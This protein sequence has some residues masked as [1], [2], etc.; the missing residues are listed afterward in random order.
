MSSFPSPVEPNAKPSS[1]SHSTP[2]IGLKPGMVGVM[3]NRTL[4][5]T[6]QLG[7]IAGLAFSLALWAYEAILLIRAHVAYAWLPMAVGTISCLLVCTLAALLT[8]LVNRA[9]LGIVF[10]ILAARLIAELAIALP[11]KIAP[12]LM[13]LF[14]PG[15]RSR[16]PAYPFNDTFQTWAG[17]GTVWLAIFFAILGLLQLTLVETAV[18][19]TTPAGRLTPYFVFIPVMLLA[20]VM[21]SNMINEQLR[22][23]LIATNDMIQFVI[24]HQ[25]A[26]VDPTIARAMHLNTV[27]TISS[28]INRPRRLFLGNYDEYFSQVDVLIDFSGEWAT[29]STVYRQAVY[30][31]PASAP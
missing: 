7:A 23:P 2:T 3:K 31:E 1:L 21:S 24:D 26:K 4:R 29:C 19:A 12:G 9:L 6:L 22:A 14:E 28:L 25:N 17:F 27:D 8:R 30:C 15:L 20:S 10:W 5:Y 13:M 16:L 11:L 18:P